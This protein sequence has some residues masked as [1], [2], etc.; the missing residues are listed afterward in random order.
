MAKSVLRAVRNVNGPIADTVT[1]MDALDQR[2]IDRAMCDLDGSPNKGNL[3]ANAILGVSLA[4][5]RAAAADLELPLYRIWVAR[6]R[7]HCRCRC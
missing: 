5:A 3:G 6:R 1:G 7:A 2:A 4:A